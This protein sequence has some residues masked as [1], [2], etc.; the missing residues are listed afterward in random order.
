VRVPEWLVENLPAWASSALGVL[1]SR[2]NLM[3]VGAVSVLLFLVSVLALP[4]L[5]ARI[6]A[7]YFSPEHGGTRRHP[8]LTALRNVFG[9]VLLLTGV[10]MLF[11]PGQGLLTIV[12]AVIFMDFPGKRRLERSIVKLGPV[13][14]AMNAIRKR[15]GQPALDLGPEEHE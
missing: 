12:A 15:A 2:Q 13:L 11:L 6:P 4:W 8:V 10:L 9:V 1:L 7:D 3:L 14:R 5:I